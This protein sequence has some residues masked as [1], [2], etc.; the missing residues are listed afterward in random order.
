M[1]CST[2][3]SKMISL[4]AKTKTKSPFHNNALFYYCS[5]C[6]TIQQ[7]AN[8]WIVFFYISLIGIFSLLWLEHYMLSAFIS[9]LI[10]CFFQL[11]KKQLLKIEEEVALEYFLDSSN[12]YGYDNFRDDISESLSK[13]SLKEIFILFFFGIFVFLFAISFL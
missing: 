4:E 12:P 6:D 3:G 5:Q 9:A 1:K 10:L 13:L 7:I 2:C 11:Q 8:K